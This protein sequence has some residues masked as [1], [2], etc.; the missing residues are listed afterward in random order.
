MALAAGVLVQCLSV[1]CARPA[2]PGGG[3]RDSIAPVLDTT[4]PPN[5]TVNFSARQITLAFDEYL[6]S[7]NIGSQ[8]T[9]A[10]PL[11]EPLEPQIKGRDLVLDIETALRD[12][13]TY[14]ISFGEAV[15][16]LTEGN[17]NRD[18]KYV[19]STGTYID[20]LSLKG[21]IRHAETGE[22][23]PDVLA[24]LYDIRDLGRRDS[25]L[26]TALPNYYAYCS[27]DGSFEMTNMREGR[28]LLVAFDDRGS[29]FKLNTGQELMAYRADTIALLPDSV[30]FYSLW[31]YQPQSKQALAGAVH[32]D[33]GLLA[34]RFRKPLEN[35]QIKPL[36]DSIEPYYTALSAGKDTGFF[37]YQTDATAMDSLALMLEKPEELRD[38]LS[39]DLYEQ[40]RLKIGLSFPESRFQAGQQ[41][42]IF[43]NYPLLSWPDSLLT[44]TEKDTFLLPLQHDSLDPRR[45]WLQCQELRSDFQVFA[46]KGQFRGYYNMPNDSLA[47][48]A[49]F[50][51]KEDLGTL[52]FKVVVEDTALYQLELLHDEQIIQK[53]VVRDSITI[54]LK[55]Y[56]PDSY[57][58]RLLLDSDENG[59]FTPGDFWEVRQ[60][61]RIYPF[62]EK[63]EIRAN[64]ELELEWRFSPP[65]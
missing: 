29:D 9:I 10:P 2:S 41:L 35:W 50:F 45:V 18:V 19:F 3:P 15:A 34:F 48:E 43:A 4:F 61:E 51:N 7:G 31:S 38:T 1:S 42:A 26:Y 23:T 60:P 5:L 49:T 37:W 53:H 25:F 12:S 8:I 17:I 14:I 62:Q 40:Q 33:R 24:A 13:T 47:F 32:K 6:K 21:V 55:N 57:S 65:N 58:A 30:Y 39:V 22:P 54:S 56:F 63:L 44:F 11:E 52:F 59:R 28:Y 16:D 27:E 46:Q 64:W 20:S 36:S